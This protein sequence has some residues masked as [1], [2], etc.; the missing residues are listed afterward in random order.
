LP[1]WP[2][3]DPAAGNLLEIGATPVVREQF[4]AERMT[5]HIDRGQASFEKLTN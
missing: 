3:F 4:L 1:V 5:F 2:A